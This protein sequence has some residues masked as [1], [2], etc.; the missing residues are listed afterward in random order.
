MFAWSGGKN[1]HQ[2]KTFPCWQT[3]MALVVT[4]ALGAQVDRLAGRLSEDFFNVVNLKG[5]TGCLDFLEICFCWKQIVLSSSLV[6]LSFLYIY[7][8]FCSSTEKPHAA[9]I[10]LKQNPTKT[11]RG[12]TISILRFFKTNLVTP[13]YNYPWIRNLGRRISK[14]PGEKI[15]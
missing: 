7:F 3:L 9:K 1:K 4:S 2:R 5:I 6:L 15:R 8:F 13:E 10:G 14:N 11:K 12:M